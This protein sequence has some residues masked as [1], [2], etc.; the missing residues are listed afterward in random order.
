MAKANLF[1]FIRRYAMA[2]NVILTVFG[3]EEVTYLHS[4]V[5]GETKSMTCNIV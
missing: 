1:N 2:R 4:D 5:E 3:P